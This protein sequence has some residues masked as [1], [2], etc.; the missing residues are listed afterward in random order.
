MLNTN[1]IL[2]TIDISII[3]FSFEL[4][5]VANLIGL[6]FHKL[7]HHI[8][9]IRTAGVLIGVF[10]GILIIVIALMLGIFIYRKRHMAGGLLY[11]CLFYD[12]LIWLN[13]CL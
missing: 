13:C 12:R 6:P 4:L 3:L 8:G 1:T 9:G 7:L 2:C 11:Q 5:F 10:G